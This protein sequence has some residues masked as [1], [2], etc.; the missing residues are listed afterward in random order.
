MTFRRRAIFLDVDGTLIDHDETLAASSVAAVRSARAAGHLVLLCTGRAR[1]EIF[2]PVAEI[3]FDGAITAGG[4]YAELRGALIAEHAMPRDLLR[5]AVDFFERESIEYIL[6]SYDAV[7]P[8]VGLTS[9]LRHLL[10]GEPG[11][12]GRSGTGR[13]DLDSI[14][15]IA[16]L[17]FFGEQPTTFAR[18]RDALAPALHVLTGTMPFLGEAGGEVSPP[19]MNKGVAI[20]EVLA[21]LEMSPDDAVA[22]GD[23]AN[24]IEMLTLVGLG[25]AMGNADGSVKAVADEVTTAVDDDGVWNAFLRHGLLGD[26]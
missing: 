22:I 12:W 26:Q 2:S 18:V 23:S 20:G 3:G 13:P 21:A 7:F 8:S 14:P 9:R 24:D 25:I 6:Q 1:A 15:S 10:G 17:T 5:T 19:G 4:G 11:E 16:K